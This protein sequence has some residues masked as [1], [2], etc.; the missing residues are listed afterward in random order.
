[1]KRDTER[2]PMPLQLPISVPQF[3]TWVWRLFIRFM[4]GLVF[5]LVLGLRLGFRS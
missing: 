3:T 4:D 1:M 5:K 2:D